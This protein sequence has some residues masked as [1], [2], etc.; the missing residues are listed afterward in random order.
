MTPRP[1]RQVHLAH[2]QLYFA[3]AMHTALPPAKCGPMMRETWKA[4][5][6]AQKCPTVFA[7]IASDLFRPAPAHITLPYLKAHLALP[8]P[9]S[10]H[11]ASHCFAFGV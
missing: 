4:Q 8:S 9:A 10:H 7:D 6:C 1:L 11:V 5:K 2:L 3:I